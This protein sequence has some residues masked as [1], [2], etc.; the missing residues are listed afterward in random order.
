MTQSTLDQI[1]IQVIMDMGYVKHKQI[2]TIFITDTM[3]D[4]RQDSIG[5]K[6]QDYQDSKFWS[7]EWVKLGAKRGELKASF[8]MLL[9][10]QSQI[11]FECI[12]SREVVYFYDFMIID[13]VGCDNCPKPEER[14]AAKVKAY[15][16]EMLRAF[17]IELYSYEL[18]EFDRSPD[19]NTFE[20][21]S[22]GRFDSMTNPPDPIPEVQSFQEL[23][24]FIETDQIIFRDWGNLDDLKGYYCTVK[25]EL[26]E[27]ITGSFNYNK[28][29]IKSLAS[30]ICPC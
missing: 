2:N 17:F 4:L 13:K 24:S 3:P 19:P 6:Y 15:T 10:Q 12:D 21:V 23:E 11:D 25:F 29:A 14:T 22:K 8:P 28:P 27:P 5:A 30:K 16:L 26:C 18:W 9:I 7:R 20:W 1:F